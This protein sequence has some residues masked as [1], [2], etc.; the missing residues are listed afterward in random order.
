MRRAPFQ[1]PFGHRRLTKSLQSSSFLSLLTESR[2]L[3][4]LTMFVQ[5]PFLSGTDLNTEQDICP[6]IGKGHPHACSSRGCLENIEVG[7]A[8]NFV[9]RTYQATCTF[10][11]DLILRKQGVAFERLTLHVAGDS[12]IIFPEVLSA[13]GQRQ[14]I[15]GTSHKRSFLYEPIYGNGC[16]TRSFEKQSVKEITGDTMD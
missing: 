2:N 1:V 16:P 8:S 9:D 7:T 13:E 12:G 14:Q 11:Q 4:S 6:D 15:S 10:F 5:Q 3:R